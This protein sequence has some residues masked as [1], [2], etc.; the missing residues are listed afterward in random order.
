MPH[1]LEFKIFVHD[2]VLMSFITTS[3]ARILGSLVKGGIKLSQESIKINNIYL[4]SQ[5]SF[6]E[7]TQEKLAEQ[8][9]VVHRQ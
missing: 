5:R 8:E 2:V 6:K 4:K 3:L 9:G 7:L 1:F